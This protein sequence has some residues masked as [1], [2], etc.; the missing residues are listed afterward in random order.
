MLHGPP[1]YRND[2]TGELCDATSAAQGDRELE[3]NRFESDHD[4]TTG[5]SWGRTLEL[6]EPRINIA[7]SCVEIGGDVGKKFL[8]RVFQRGDFSET[9]AE[10]AIRGLSKAHSTPRF[11][12]AMPI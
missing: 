8:P 4:E 10:A 7:K 3:G 1:F 9:L 2:N 11:T 5:E 6:S 12:A